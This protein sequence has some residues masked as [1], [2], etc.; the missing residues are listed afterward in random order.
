MSTSSACV[1]SCVAR[2]ECKGVVSGIILVGARVVISVAGAVTAA[3]GLVTVVVAIGA[4]LVAAKAV[5]VSSDTYE[6]AEAVVAVVAVVVVV[7]VVAA[8]EDGDR[9]SAFA[10]SGVRG[11]FLGEP[12]PLVSGLTVFELLLLA[13]RVGEDS[14]GGTGRPGNRVSGV[15]SPFPPPG[16]LLMLL[17]LLLLLWLTVVVPSDVK[18]DVWRCRAT[19]PGAG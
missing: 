2:L 4:L 14:C 11:P 15:K 10:A 6:G 7:V 12:A 9:M 3:G 13:I 16:W 5:N 17:L 1:Y 19:T 8:E 18:G